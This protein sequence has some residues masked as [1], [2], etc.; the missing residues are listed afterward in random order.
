MSWSSNRPQRE[1]PIT[2]PKRAWWDSERARMTLASAVGALTVI[3]CS[4]IWGE[5]GSC[6][7]R[8]A[9]SDDQWIV[10]PFDVPRQSTDP[11]LCSWVGA[12]DDQHASDHLDCRVQRGS[13]SGH[14]TGGR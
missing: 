14:R 7:Q 1:A 5:T 11:L 8:R 3:V 9:F 4:H 12:V 13:D 6:Q 10:D 2:P